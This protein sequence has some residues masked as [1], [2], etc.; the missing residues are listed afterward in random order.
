MRFNAKHVRCVFSANQFAQNQMEIALQ[1]AIGSPNFVSRDNDST[2]RNA[3][4][5]NRENMPEKASARSASFLPVSAPKLMEYIPGVTE[6]KTAADLR[7]EHFASKPMA[8]AYAGAFSSGNSQS[9]FRGRRN[10]KY[11]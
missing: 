1:N 2:V 11:R 5:L 6:Y 7:R 9:G 3:R 8:V 10:N 4:P